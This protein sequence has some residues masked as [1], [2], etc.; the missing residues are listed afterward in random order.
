MSEI[1]NPEWIDWNVGPRKRFENL[2][3]LLKEL[4][5]VRNLFGPHC[6]YAGGPIDLEIVLIEQ[7]I[8][9]QN[10]GGEN[11]NMEIVWEIG[12]NNN[13][14]V[15]GHFK[16]E[17]IESAENIRQLNGGFEFKI[18]HIEHTYARFIP[19]PGEQGGYLT[20]R[21]WRGR[22]GAF[23]VTVVYP[24]WDDELRVPLIEKPREG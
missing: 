3:E 5:T 18:D 4:K 6:G 22:K 19:Y 23:A 24:V 2:E 14:A 11:L 21:T 7:R 17:E 8:E 13:A 12:E 10:G 9:D 16:K 1:C 15:R 20:D